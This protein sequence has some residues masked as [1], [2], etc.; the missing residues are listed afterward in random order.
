M[1][2]IQIGETDRFIEMLD[3]SA[4]F[5]RIFQ[6]S[7][8]LYLAKVSPGILYVEFSRLFKDLGVPLGATSREVMRRKYG[9][10]AVDLI[11]ELLP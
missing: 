10:E 1:D 4:D 6:R 2:P 8:F 9:Q 5:Q 7:L 11:A 3:H